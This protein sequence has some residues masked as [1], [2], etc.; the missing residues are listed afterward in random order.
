[1]VASPDAGIFFRKRHVS[2]DLQAGYG[3]SNI[4]GVLSLS[5]SF[6]WEE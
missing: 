4:Y 1:M 5:R 2:L 3:S 6:V